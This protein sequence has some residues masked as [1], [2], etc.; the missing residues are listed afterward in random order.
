MHGAAGSA[1]GGGYA[2]AA[3]LLAFDQAMKQGKLLEPG[4][5]SEFYGARG[6]AGGAPGTNTVLNSGPTWTVI[7]L[8][9]LDPPAGQRIGI[10]IA[11]ALGR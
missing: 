3:D 9:N 10:A 6:I 5:A 1:A 7:V 2:T 8:S 4:R 11:R